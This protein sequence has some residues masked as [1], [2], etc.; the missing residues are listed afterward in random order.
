MASEITIP[1]ILEIYK[2]ST[3]SY[4][5]SRYTGDTLVTKL[6]EN[7][8]SIQNMEHLLTLK[9]RK[10]NINFAVYALYKY[11]LDVETPYHF[12]ILFDYRVK[13]IRVEHID[14]AINIKVDD[15]QDFPDI[16]EKPNET[17]KTIV[18][19]TTK[20][21]GVSTRKRA[22]ESNEIVIDK[23]SIKIKTIQR[24]INDKNF[25]FSYSDIVEFSLRWWY[26]NDY[27][28]NFKNTQFPASCSGLVST[29]LCELA[30][31]RD[32][33][34]EEK[35]VMS[36]EFLYNKAREAKEKYPF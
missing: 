31:G 10:K 19:S 26:Q 17:A 8:L 11:G 2:Q 22:S 28:S 20:T 15:F 6:E 32:T 16:L 27:S 30:G 13:K 21:K 18:A 3:V 23:M 7:A 29:L 4:L 34:S 24:A 33:S 12:I 25:N 9:E 36:P 5:K 14:K 35:D 1:E